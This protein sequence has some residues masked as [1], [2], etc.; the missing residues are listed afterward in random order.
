MFIDLKRHSMAAALAVVFV[1]SGLGSVSG[2]V[3]TDTRALTRLAEDAHARN[4]QAQAQAWVLAAILGVPI[5]QTVHGVDMELARF[6]GNRPIYRTTCNLEAAETIS[7][8][9]LWP[10]GSLGLSLN[11]SGLTLGQFDEGHVLFTHQEFTGRATAGNTDT[12][13]AAHPTYVGG[14][15]IAAGI[16]AQ[17]KG[18]SFAANLLSFGWDNDTA[19]MTTAAANGLRISNHSYVYTGD[20]WLYG[21]YLSNCVDWD[22]LAYNAPYYLICEA[23]GNSQGGN[24]QGAYV[25]IWPNG[26]A[27]NILTVGAVWPILG[28]YQGNPSSISLASFSSCGPTQDGRIK[29]DVCGCGVNVYTSDWDSNTSY[30]TVSGT[31]LACPNVSGACGLLIGDYENLHSGNDMRSATLKALLIH[32]ADH[33]NTP[34]PD[35]ELGWGVVNCKTAANLLA[36]Q[37][38]H[39][40]M[41]QEQTLSSGQTF[42]F[43]VGSLGTQP[44]KVTICWTDPAGTEPTE[45]AVSPYSYLELVNDLMLR[46]TNGSTTYYP[47]VL[48]PTNPSNAA[49]TG[50]NF[51]DNVEQVYIPSPT[52]GVY[53]ITV[54]PRNSTLQPSGTQAFSIVVTGQS[55]FVSGTA[56]LQDYSGNASSVPVTVDLRTPGTTTALESHTVY[57]DGSGNFAFP[58]ALNGTYDV[59]CNGPHWLRSV[60]SSVAVSD[61]AVTPVT[62]SLVNGDVNGDNVIDLADLVA[63]AAA[64]RSSPGMSNYNANADLNG[65]GVIDLLDW[66]IVARNWHRQG[67]P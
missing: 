39:P 7:A 60:A 26:T 8:N 59:A 24:G 32:T 13:Y 57:V 46:V 18:M 1:A 35:Y 34:A 23:A 50:D 21:F 29:P 58:T 40:V 38:T 14:T 51:R 30:A 43:R 61:S 28:G 3:V 65:D 36:S 19:D 33:P 37:V 25:S 67:A 11:G 2:Q 45:G 63:I 53:T 48:D 22:T 9:Q 44:L 55:S 15:M 47:W 66:M 49:T 56:A 41:I 52:A 20:N 64:W 10:G 6:A 31:S 62:F 5:R 27:K 4:V 12:T 16:N 54:T 42:S 17:A